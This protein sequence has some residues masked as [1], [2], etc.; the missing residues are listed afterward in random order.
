MRRCFV[1]LRKLS[2]LTEAQM[3]LLAFYKTTLKETSG[4]VH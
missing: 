1:D 2:L 4:L 3:L